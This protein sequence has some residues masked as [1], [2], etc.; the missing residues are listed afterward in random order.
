MRCAACY[1]QVP[2]VALV[3]ESSMR[4]I[5]GGKRLCA[6]LSYSVDNSLPDFGGLDICTGELRRVWRL[7]REYAV[8]MPLIRKSPGLLCHGPMELTSAIGG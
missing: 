7:I 1:T 8:E 6:M 2:V 3:L 5:P 4:P